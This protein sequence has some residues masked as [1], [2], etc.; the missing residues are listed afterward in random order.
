MMDSCHSDSVL[1]VWVRK[2]D[3]QMEP[4]DPE[5]INQTLFA[6][7]RTLGRPDAFVARELTDSVLHFLAT[8]SGSSVIASADIHDWVVKVVRELGQPDLAQAY[9][10]YAQSRSRRTEAEGGDVA[11]GVGPTLAQIT[12]WLRGVPQAEQIRGRIADAVLEAFSLRH[13]LSPNLTT[14]VQDGLLALGGLT[15]PRELSAAVVRL[16]AIQR[17]SPEAALDGFALLRRV[18]NYVSDTVALDTPERELSLHGLRIGEVPAWLRHLNAAASFLGLRVILNLGAGHGEKNGGRLGCGS[19][20]TESEAAQSEDRLRGFR[21]VLVEETLALGPTSA[22]GIDWHLSPSDFE[23]GDGQKRFLAL[24][25]AALR[26]QPIRFVRGRAGSPKPLAE[27]LDEKHPA[28]LLWATLNLGTLRQRIGKVTDPEEL[29]RRTLSLVR[30][31]ISAGT[32]KRDFIRTCPQGHRPPFL[33]DQA[34]VGI[35]L[36]GLMEIV[37]EAFGGPDA[38]AAS[39]A[40]AFAGRFYQVLADALPAEARRGA[41]PVV[42]EDRTTTSLGARNC[43]GLLRLGRNVARLHDA[44]GRGTWL[45]GMSDCAATDVSGIA[46]FLEGLWKRSALCRIALMP[47]TPHEETTPLFDR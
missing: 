1:P 38:L 28:I 13:V 42:L 44:A 35:R 14:A 22:V 23:P 40:W 15:S 4:F 20:F 30:L 33:L 47:V 9:A 39:E 34:A 41:L 43:E 18:R 17:E 19:L 21:E 29:A 36:A 6:A 45:V 16:L 8:E 26:G 31:A 2:R 5:K 27:G 24:L 10:E 11:Q 7:L 37:A 25:R 12:Q 32:Q 3:G 46:K